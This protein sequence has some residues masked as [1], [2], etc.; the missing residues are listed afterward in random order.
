MVPLAF[1]SVP[2]KLT[3]A[4]SAVI[5][6]VKVLK[7]PPLIFDKFK[8]PPPETTKPELFVSVPASPTEFVPVGVQPP[9]KL[10]VVP[11]LTL[12][13]TCPEVGRNKLT[14]PAKVIL[15]PL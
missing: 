4:P 7:L 10:T 14:A 5:G 1:V 9:L 13:C 11:L 2:L 6:T 8:V 15:P 12:I 3:V